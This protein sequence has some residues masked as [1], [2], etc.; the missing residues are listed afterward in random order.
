MGGSSE[1]YRWEG[2]H[3]LTESRLH[4]GGQRNHCA[5]AWDFYGLLGGRIHLQIIY[6]RKLW[7]FNLYIPWWLLP[8]FLHFFLLHNISPILKLNSIDIDKP[9]KYT[10]R[11]INARNCRPAPSIGRYKMELMSR[12]EVRVGQNSLLRVY[13]DESVVVA[14]S[15]SYIVLHCI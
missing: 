9:Y 14:S 15:Y 8:M 2:C 4:H 3:Y 11:N 13:N 5:T 7:Q 6:L 1:A 12:N 10:N